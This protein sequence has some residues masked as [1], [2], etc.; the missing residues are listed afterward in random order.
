M[1]LAITLN[2]V[3]IVLLVVLLAA[4]MS[5]PFLLPS[6]ERVQARMRRRRAARS[7]RAERAPYLAM[8][9]AQGSFAND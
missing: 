5:L 7:L 2:I 8:R 3:F 9:K 4:T 6:G 1:T